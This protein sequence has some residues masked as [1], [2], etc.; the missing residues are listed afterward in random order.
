VAQKLTEIE[1]SSN[2]NSYKTC[3][4]CCAK[5][6]RYGGNRG[7]HQLCYKEGQTDIKLA[8]MRFQRYFLIDTD[9]A[10]KHGTL[11]LGGTMQALFDYRGNYNVGI[12]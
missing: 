6:Q 3:R 2:L 1:R 7:P 11:Y 10:A 8:K 4:N 5:R 12:R 9:I